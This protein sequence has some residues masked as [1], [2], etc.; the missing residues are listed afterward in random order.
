MG[1]ITCAGI[2]FNGFLSADF[3]DQ[4][5]HFRNELRR[6]RFLVGDL[7]VDTD[8]VQLDPLAAVLPF[9]DD[10]FFALAQGFIRNAFDGIGHDFIFRDGLA[11][12]VADDDVL[13]RLE[14]L[15]DVAIRAVL[16]L[17]IAVLFGYFLGIVLGRVDFLGLSAVLQGDRDGPAHLDVAAVV[18]F[19]RR[20]VD[21]IVIT[22]V[23]IIF[24][25]QC[26]FID[27]VGIYLAGFAIGNEGH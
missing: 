25:H 1:Y 18:E 8:D 16:F 23:D 21:F 19:L 12:Y 27:S 6:Q 24:P 7:A 3:A 17:I 10:F 2:D 4:R 9:L 20:N 5:L 11:R 13:P 14:R 26:L 22:D 15:L